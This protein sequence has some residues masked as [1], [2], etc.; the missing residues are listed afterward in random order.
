MEIQVFL[1]GGSFKKIE[2][3]TADNIGAV[4][5][6]TSVFATLVFCFIYLT[7]LSLPGLLNKKVLENNLKERI[8]AEF[9]LRI[10]TPTE[11]SYAILP[12]PHFVAK[13]VKEKNEDYR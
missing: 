10:N 9:K 8:F 12:T 4:A 13:N 2:P 1:S 6:I 3:R 11:I 7:Y 5:I